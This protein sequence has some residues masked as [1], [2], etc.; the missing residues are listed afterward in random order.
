MRYYIYLSL[1]PL[2]WAGNWVVGRGIHEI[3]APSALNFSRWTLAL[4]V[5]LPFG[6]RPVI[7]AWPIVR[8]EWRR[9]VVLGILG[10]GLFQLIVYQGLVYTTAINAVIINA[11]LTFFI[12]LIS[13]LVLREKLNRLQA[14]GVAISFIGIL[15]IVGRGD[16]TVILR[17]D[18]GIGDLLI[19]AAMPLWA[20]YTVILKR[21][22]TALDAIPLLTVLAVVGWAFMGLIFL[23]DHLYFGQTIPVGDQRIW[24]PLIYLAIFPSIVGFLFWNE[25]IKH[26]GPNIASF[27]YPLMPLYGT[28]LAII[29]LGETLFWFQVIGM[30]AI[31]GGVYLSTVQDSANRSRRARAAHLQVESPEKQKA[32]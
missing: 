20:V 25:G 8:E 22:P 1:A 16:P 9:L 30:V 6:I 5:L 21:W 17:L 12:L 11:S 14:I 32:E 19:L 15:T 3:I 27:L 31:L 10:V 13:W 18:Y 4:V 7:Q 29:F 26:L 24:L 2:F 28:V 23:A